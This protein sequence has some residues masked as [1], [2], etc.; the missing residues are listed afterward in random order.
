MQA[1]FLSLRLFLEGIEVP[2]V[3][4]QIEIGGN[5]PA[6]AVLQVVPTGAG[7]FLK[8]R[9]C[10]HLFAV[11]P[12][13]DDA[14]QEDRIRYKLVFGG[15]IAGIQWVKTP[16]QRA[17]V[18]QCLDWSSYWDTAYQMML[19]FDEMMTGSARFFGAAAGL[20]DDL[21]NTPVWV[22][23]RLLNGDPESP[24]LQQFKGS[25]LLGGLISVIE[26]VGGVPGKF[27]GAND[28]FNV[29]ELRLKL[30]QQVGASRYDDTNKLMN[31][32]A[33]AEFF[34]GQT[35]NLGPLS[36]VRDVLKMAMQYIFYE[37]YPNPA[38]YYV[39]EKRETKTWQETRTTELVD[40][41]QLSQASNQLSALLAMC[42]E[43][44][45]A[46]DWKAKRDILQKISDL[47]YKTEKTLDSA[48]K[49]SRSAQTTTKIRR[50]SELVHECYLALS[51]R[52]SNYLSVSGYEFN[53]TTSSYDLVTG[54]PH[55]P[56]R[57]FHDDLTRQT[58]D[59]TPYNRPLNFVKV[60]IQEA[61]KAIGSIT[62]FSVSGQVTKSKE[63]IKGG[64]L[65]TQIFR[66]DIFFAAPPRCNVFFPDMYS[67][68]S[69]SRNFLQE[70]TR[71]RL[72]T[73]HW[74]FGSDALFDGRYYA[75]AGFFARSAPDGNAG[76]YSPISKW[77]MPHE[78][79]VGVVPK[80]DQISEI[81]FFFRGKDNIVTTYDTMT[82]WVDNPP[83]AEDL[84]MDQTTMELLGT[85]QPQQSRQEAYLAEK[86]IPKK[87]IERLPFAQN[88][89]N[90]KFHL[91]RYAPRT[92]TVDGGPVNFNLVAGFPALIMD[93]PYVDGTCPPQ[94]LGQ[95]VGLSHSASQDGSNTSSISLSHVRTHDGREDEFIRYMSTSEATKE[96]P[97]TTVLV[98]SAEIAAGRVKPFLRCAT[99][100]TRPYEIGE[101]G[102]KGGKIV[103]VKPSQKMIILKDPWERFYSECFECGIPTM[104]PSLNPPGL[105]YR[106]ESP[107]E[108]TI[109]ESIEIVENIQVD[110]GKV[111]VPFEDTVKPPW[112]S[113]VFRSA[114]IGTKFYN[115]ILGT[116]SIVDELLTLGEEGKKEVLLWEGRKEQVQAGVSVSVK[117]AVEYLTQVY[118]T[119]R[120]QG[121]DV[122]RFASEYVSRPLASLRDILGDE[123]VIW[124]A[125]TGLPHLPPDS[126]KVDF[127]VGFHGPG[128]AQLDGL[129]GLPHVGAKLPRVNDPK[130]LEVIESKLDPRPKRIAAVQD[131]L[132]EILTKRWV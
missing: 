29:A 107:K 125:A 65:M 112:M 47:C 21:F 106:G 126:K 14:S 113:H 28:F 27:R 89:A 13:S 102:P 97:L 111:I 39:P 103:S 51:G 100:S 2:I 4:A 42:E 98:A 54:A 33:W 52:Y 20:F 123:E 1:K 30:T 55:G 105:P 71:L 118:G 114:N 101:V 69:Y 116:G 95:I 129:K 124:D 41:D 99:I 81:N 74:L 119:L 68:F 44:L 36:S 109:P 96:L 26:A 8:P 25:G 122:A 90:Y 18:L 76:A 59:S 104:G 48:E 87:K 88:V 53:V 5:S 85:N 128:V 19:T 110:G 83:T 32:K 131:Y 38:P 37:V 94:F 61:G 23:N 50:A 62:K 108:L 3:S 34:D 130:K 132:R 60:R 86:K 82:Y 121:Y 31:R 24:Y 84:E 11:E 67:N 43:G 66:P 127:E 56:G 70:I 16:F 77:L 78:Q 64:L 57:V 58:I 91:Y 72:R 115:E 63:E 15:E 120:S 75:P 7:L 17:L 49:T 35:A 10:V 73:S 45:A 93:E 22:T 79:F 12:M 6:S 46:P 9:T 117:T 80:T 40:K 92:A